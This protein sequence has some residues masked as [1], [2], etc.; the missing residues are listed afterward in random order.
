ARDRARRPFGVVVIGPAGGRRHRELARPVVVQRLAGPVGTATAARNLVRCQ[1]VCHPAAD[2]AGRPPGAGGA[3]GRG[4]GGGGRGRGG[5]W[6][7]GLGAVLAV[8]ALFLV[9][10]DGRRAV[11]PG[12][13]GGH[14]NAGLVLLGVAAALAAGAA[15]ALGAFLVDSAAARGLA[16]ATA[17]L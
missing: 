13:R 6:A 12:I 11:A 9:P 10:P 14:V 8:A 7:F 4:L 17:G 5:G 2:P 1:T 16:P 15:N 3:P